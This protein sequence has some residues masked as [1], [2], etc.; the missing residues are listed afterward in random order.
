MRAAQY[1]MKDAAQKNQSRQ[2]QADIVM[3]WRSQ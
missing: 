2:L 3:T 1:A